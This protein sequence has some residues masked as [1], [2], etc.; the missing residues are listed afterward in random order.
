MKIASNTEA[1]NIVVL[2]TWNPA[3]FSPEWAKENLADDK[4]KEVVLSI[5]MPPG[6]VPNRLTVDDVNV[7]VSPAS[8]S[9]DYINYV[10]GRLDS[11][12]NK[13]SLISDL[14]KHT[15]VSAVGIN[16]RFTGNITENAELLNLF[17]LSDAAKINSTEFQLSETVIR[18]SF[19]LED[20]TTLNL[21]I[22]NKSEELRFEFNF[23]SEIKSLADLK[24]KISIEK[25]VSYQNQSIKFLSDVYDITLEE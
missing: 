14:L 9:I 12:F 1:F 5:A 24:A 8:L 2:G 22:E 18:R 13:L 15:P 3:V 21:T 11:S 25:A 6:I 23:H 7:Y 4:T 19:K 20:N 17:S 10:A 16:F